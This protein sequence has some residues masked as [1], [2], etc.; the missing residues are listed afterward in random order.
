MGGGGAWQRLQVGPEGQGQ[1]QVEN[2]SRECS[3]LHRRFCRSQA[4]DSGPQLHLHPAPLGFAAQ[5]QALAS[6][7]REK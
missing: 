5:G 2:A 4:A 6:G 7:S 3:G 1:G